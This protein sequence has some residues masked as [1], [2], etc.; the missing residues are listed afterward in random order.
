MMNKTSTNSE[1]SWHSIVS[2]YNKPRISRSV[3][4]I[5]NSV[6]SY[7][8][9][10][11]AIVL[12]MKVSVWL[13]IPLIL[14][15]AGLLVRIFIIFHDC[16][17]G[18]FF[19]SKKL[20]RIVG[21]ACG[22]LSF[23][24][25]DKWTDSHL[26]HHQTVGNLDKRGDGDVWTM[27]VE[28]YQSSSSKKQFLYRLFRHPLFLIVFGGPLNFMI[29]SRFTR[30]SMTK[31]QKNNIYFTNVIL[32]LLIAGM[33]WLIGWQTFLLI[34]IPVMALAA[35]GGIYLF[36]FQHQFEDVTWRR[37]EDWNYKDM[38]LD[39]SSFFKLPKI[40]QWFT[41][42][43]GFHHVHHLGPTIPN[44]NLAKCHNENTI[45]KGIKPFTMIH[46]FYALNLRLW[47]E[48]NQRIITFREL[49]KNLA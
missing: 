36:Y 23:T 26:H 32:A 2:E 20:N 8:L 47:D 14:L 37:N 10:W 12:L 13:T 48:K 19:R 31:K 27:T 44:Y 41:G 45:F 21:S 49:K 5:I 6:G 7:M 22:I 9:V 39:G 3:W 34:Q 25:Y 38:A 46:S 29:Y 11:V 28:E 42:N 4:Q 43:I 24:P 18:S 33:S 40:L 1:K 30:R 16:G 17:H 15:A 35:M